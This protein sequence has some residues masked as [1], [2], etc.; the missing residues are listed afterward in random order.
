MTIPFF[1]KKDKIASNEDAKGVTKRVNSHKLAKSEEEEMKLQFMAKLIMQGGILLLTDEDQ[2]SSYPDDQLLVS[3][4]TILIDF[5]DTLMAESH[6]IIVKLEVAM[7]TRG[8]ITNEILEE[9]VQSMRML[10]S[11]IQVL[12]I[13]TTQKIEAKLNKKNNSKA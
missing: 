11:V 3:N 6:S 7:L 4:G 9:H 2:A 5:E 10:S 13:V 1:V 8:I 12:E